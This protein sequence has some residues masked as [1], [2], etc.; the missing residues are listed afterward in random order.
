[1]TPNNIT[2]KDNIA[3]LS[4]SFG[5]VLV[6]LE[7]KEIKDTY[8]IGDEIKGSAFIEDTIIVDGNVRGIA[9]YE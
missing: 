8:S 3:Y 9:F 1:M 7:N 4:S 2:I 5:L 6:D